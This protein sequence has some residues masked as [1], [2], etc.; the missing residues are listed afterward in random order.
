M[1]ECRL[2]S[3]YNFDNDVLA[4]TGTNLPFELN[5]GVTIRRAR[6]GFEGK[7]FKIWDYKFEY[8]FTRGNGS[9]A[10]GVTDAFIRL[11]VDKPFSV[12]MVRSRSRS[13][14]RKPPATAFSRL[15]NGIWRSIRFL[16]IPTPTRPV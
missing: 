6:L 10:A 16:T 12:K 9:L 7:F 1:V 2:D 3:Q 5:S 8:D 11:N 4:A 14:W 13:V 15:L